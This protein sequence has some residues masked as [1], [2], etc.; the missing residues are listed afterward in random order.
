MHPILSTNYTNLAIEWMER[1][2]KRKLLLLFKVVFVVWK[3]GVRM[4]SEDSGCSVVVI[5]SV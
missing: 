2:V 4:H 5:E 3:K 1:I